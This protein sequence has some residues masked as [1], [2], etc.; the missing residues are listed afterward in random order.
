M[1]PEHPHDCR[2]VL[3]QRVQLG[4]RIPDAVQVRKSAHE[5][6][7]PPAGVRFRRRAGS[8]SNI[9]RRSIKRRE[10]RSNAVLPIRQHPTVAIR[11]ESVVYDMHSIE[12]SRAIDEKIRIRPC[13]VVLVA[14]VECK[15]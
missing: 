15:F 14:P 10:H 13:G 7:E 8:I 1:I 9:C 5:R 2:V 3:L 4:A 11:A 12:F 6:V